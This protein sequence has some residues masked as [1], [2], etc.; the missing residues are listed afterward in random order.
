MTTT[1]SA[2]RANFTGEPLPVLHR[3]LLPTDL[4]DHSSRALTLAILLARQ[5]DAEL[6]LAHALRAPTPIFEIESPERRKAEEG[7]ELLMNKMHMQGIKAK[8]VLIKGSR[9]IPANIIECAKFFAADLIVVGSH[10]RRGLAR[11]LRGSIS[12]IVVKEATCPV[13]VVRER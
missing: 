10:S 3:I 2:R 11:Y 6:V 4:A 13:L 1:L 5:N 7:L 9:S 8:R 12:A